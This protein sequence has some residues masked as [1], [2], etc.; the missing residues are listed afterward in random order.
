LQALRMIVNTDFCVAQCAFR[1]TDSDT[2]LP[3][4]RIVVS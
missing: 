4:S 1:Q 2:P 3:T